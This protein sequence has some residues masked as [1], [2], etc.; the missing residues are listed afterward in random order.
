M[1]FGTSFNT[2]FQRLGGSGA[3]KDKKTL[4][5]PP[6]KPVKGLFCCFFYRDCYYKRSYLLNLKF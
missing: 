5:P 2:E 3:L 6:S 4:N 1:S